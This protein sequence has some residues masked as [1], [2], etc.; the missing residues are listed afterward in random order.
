MPDGINGDQKFFQ[1]HTGQGQS[2]L[3][4]EV[5]VWGDRKPYLQFD[6]VE[7]L[8]AA[9][10]VGALELHPWNCEP[11]LPEQPGRLVFDLDPAPDVPF[12]AVIAGG[13]RGEGP[14]GGPRAWSASARPRAAR[15]C[16]WSRR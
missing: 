6:R 1:R 9:A 2:A 8:V 4:T 5:E 3:I 16:T 12:E 7:A 13:A 10:Q 11:F 14:A 15:A